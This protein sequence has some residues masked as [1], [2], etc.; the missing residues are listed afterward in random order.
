[1]EPYEEYGPEPEN[2]KDERRILFDC[3]LVNGHNDI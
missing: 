1:M 2:Y 3:E